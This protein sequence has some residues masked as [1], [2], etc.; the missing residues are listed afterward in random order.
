MLKDAV[1]Q[2]SLSVFCV[3]LCRLFVRVQD[4]SV[5]MSI[6]SDVST[7]TPLL[8]HSGDYKESMQGTYQLLAALSSRP[9]PLH[10]IPGSC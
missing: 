7:R 9:H 8:W 5:V 6:C 2:I 4:D 3:S 1:M 10:E